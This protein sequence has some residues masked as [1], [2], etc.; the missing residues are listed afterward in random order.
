[1][2]EFL[3]DHFCPSCLAHIINIL[4]RMPTSCTK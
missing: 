3:E 4:W 1:L 2:F